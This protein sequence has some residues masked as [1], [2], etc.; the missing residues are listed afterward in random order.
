MHSRSDFRLR[1][2]GD[3]IENAAAAI[4]LNPSVHGR[5]IAELQV[6]CCWRLPA[7]IGHKSGASP[8]RAGATL[9]KGPNCG[10]RIVDT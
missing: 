7:H 9:F 2:Y 3:D 10:V 6:E 5:V 1:H 4:S 8:V